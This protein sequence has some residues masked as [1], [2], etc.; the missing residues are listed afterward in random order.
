MYQENDMKIKVKITQLCQF[1]DTAKSKNLLMWSISIPKAHSNYSK[2]MDLL[3]LLH[4][5]HRKDP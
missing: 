5:D 2:R 3:I 4:V 1:Y